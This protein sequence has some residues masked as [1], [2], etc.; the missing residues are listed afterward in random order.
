MKN[1]RQPISSPKVVAIVLMAPTAPNKTMAMI[2]LNEG[3]KIP[4]PTNQ[5]LWSILKASP[6]RVSLPIRGSKLG[7]R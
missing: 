2:P 1:P 3:V 6:H 5:V 7:Y 4:I